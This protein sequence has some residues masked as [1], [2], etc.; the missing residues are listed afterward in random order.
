MTLVSPWP[1]RPRQPVG[2][3][4]RHALVQRVELGLGRSRRARCRRCSVAMTTRRCSWS[5]SIMRCVGQDAPAP[6]TRRVVRR[7][8]AAPLFEPEA[9]QVGTRGE[10]A[11]SRLP[12]PCA[13]ASVGLSRSRLSSGCERRD[14][15]PLG[16][17]DDRRVVGLG[18]EPSSESLNPPLPCC[19][20]WQAPWLQPSFVRT[21]TISW[22]KLTGRGTAGPVAAVL[23]RGHGRNQNEDR[24][25]EGTPDLH[26]RFPR[27]AAMFNIAL[28][29][30][31]RQACGGQ[32]TGRRLD[33]SGKIATTRAGPACP[34]D[35]QGE[36]RDL[37]PGRG[38]PR[39][40]SRSICEYGRSHWWAAQ[41]TPGSC[42]GQR[43][44][45]LPVERAVPAPGVDPHD[46]DAPR[47]RAS[48]WPR[49][50]P[51]SPADVVGL[52]VEGVPPGP[53]SAR[54]PAA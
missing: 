36:A 14:P 7:R 40:T 22:R 34:L 2:V 32:C 45:G 51:H 33:Q 52:A 17:L 6:V 41:K 29:L 8:A 49:A 37:E 35:L 15:P 31:Q 23:R 48:G 50:S 47:R 28:R 20:P 39:F 43:L 25:G 4:L 21:G 46:P 30:V 24:Q 26:G 1:T 42:A 53:A 5:G 12:P 13:T 54:C 10:P 3:D 9:D 16:A 11:S 38:Q 44:A 18:L 19:E 27:V